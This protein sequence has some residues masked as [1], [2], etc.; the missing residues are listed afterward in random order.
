MNDKRTVWKLCQ[1]DATL[2]Q[3]VRD[4]GSECGLAG[5]SVTVDGQTATWGSEPNGRRNWESQRG[6]P[7][8][9]EDWM[10][11]MREAGL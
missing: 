9:R 8:D 11:G 4:A 5:I 7:R 1:R 3:L 2:A 6:D 10:R